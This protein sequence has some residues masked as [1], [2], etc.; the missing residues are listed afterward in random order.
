MLGLPAAYG[1]NCARLDGIYRAAEHQLDDLLYYQVHAIE[2]DGWNYTLQLDS[3]KRD[4]F[5]RT[6]ADGV[7]TLQ[8]DSAANILYLKRANGDTLHFGAL[9]NRF[10][11]Y[12]SVYTIDKT[13][14][15]IYTEHTKKKAHSIAALYTFGDSITHRLK[16]PD[17]HVI[18][19]NDTALFLVCRAFTHEKNK[20]PRN[21]VIY[22]S[23]SGW[24]IYRDQHHTPIVIDPDTVAW[25]TP[26]YILSTT[27]RRPIT[28]DCAT[29]YAFTYTVYY[30]GAMVDSFPVLDAFFPKV[31]LV[32][33]QDSLHLYYNHYIPEQNAYQ[34][35][36]RLYSSGARTYT[37]D[38][39]THKEEIPRPYI[40]KR[41]GNYWVVLYYRYMLMPVD[42]QNY[43]NVNQLQI[44]I[45]GNM[46]FFMLYDFE[47]QAFLGF[48]KVELVG[49]E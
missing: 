43:M 16:L 48:P 42:Q 4:P 23:R 46:P 25:F 38:A 10:Y 39:I 1:Q 8:N 22:L 24:D 3:A 35:H 34:D 2:K 40:L 26:E 6:L 36:F 18:G 49:N 32:N 11:A 27:N 13:V 31:R 5:R 44:D 21:T 19:Q 9:S 17:Q 41:F 7:T 30:K 37:W 14:V 47:T 15:H 33:V 12:L 28:Y 20:Y 29:V 45:S